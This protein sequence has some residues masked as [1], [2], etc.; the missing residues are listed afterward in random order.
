[1][2]MLGPVEFMRMLRERPCAPNPKYLR[3]VEEHK[4]EKCMRKLTDLAAKFPG[5]V[6]LVT[7]DDDA[8]APDAELH[9]V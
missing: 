6:K 4:A 3:I 1:M 2:Q 5:I 9:S 8:S 7:H